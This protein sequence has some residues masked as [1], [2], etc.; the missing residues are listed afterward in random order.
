MHSYVLGCKRIKGSH[1]YLNIAEVINKIT[2]I[3]NINSSK[4]S[5]CV[6]GNAS[7]FGKAF[8]TFSIHPQSNCSSSNNSINNWFVS[9]ND[10]SSSEENN[11]EVDNTCENVDIT[12]LSTIFSNPNVINSSDNDDEICLP[13]HLTCSAHTLSLIATTDVNKIEDHSYNQISKPVFEK[14]YL[15]FLEFSQ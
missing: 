1:T 7:N 13:D 3:F 15:L 12:E 8:R 10:D 4:I 14:L 11:L 9:D 6:T 2:K 5:H